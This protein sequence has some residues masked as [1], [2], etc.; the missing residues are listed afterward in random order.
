MHQL[1]GEGRLF[2]VLLVTSGTNPA[3]KLERLYS[4]YDPEHRIVVGTYELLRT[5]RAGQ[6]KPSLS[7]RLTQADFDDRRRFIIDTVRRGS[8]YDVRRLITSL[9]RS[10]GFA[11]IRQQVRKCCA[12]IRSE[13]KRSRPNELLPEFPT[14]LPY[15]SRLRAVSVPLNVWLSA[16]ALKA[17]SIGVKRQDTS[18]NSASPIAF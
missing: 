7:W 6:S 9:Y 13:Y 8:T 12:L 15:V 17:K 4:A 14:V 1:N 2:W 18:E 5:S 10:P 16:Q 11:P 3:H